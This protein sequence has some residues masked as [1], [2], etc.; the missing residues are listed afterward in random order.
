MHLERVLG[1]LELQFQLVQSPLKDILPSVAILE[2]PAGLGFGL[3]D[4]LELGAEQGFGLAAHLLRLFRV[5]LLVL[6]LLEPT[7]VQLL[8]DLELADAG[9]EAGVGSDQLFVRLVCLTVYWGRGATWGGTGHSEAGQRL[10]LELRIVDCVV[11]G[12]VRMVHVWGRGARDGRVC[13]VGMSIDRFLRRSPCSEGCEGCR[14]DLALSIGAVSFRRALEV[15][16]LLLLADD[17]SRGQREAGVS[18]ME[19]GMTYLLLLH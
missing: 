12:Q 8:D 17:V 15:L 5:G 16:L 9:L 6:E 2:L 11:H 1:T 14:A 10:C 3:C 13:V 7:P 18:V 19:S 4:G